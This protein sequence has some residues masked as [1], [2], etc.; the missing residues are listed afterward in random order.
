M[1]SLFL[2]LNTNKSV[3]DIITSIS[4]GI[5]TSND[6]K[7]IKRLL[8]NL[9]KDFSKGIMKAKIESETNSFTINEIIIVSSGC[10][11]STDKIVK[12]FVL[13]FPNKVILI[14]EKTRLGK[15]NALNKIFT[16]FSGDYLVLIPA[17]AL[18]SLKNIDLLIKRMIKDSNA[19]IAF[20]R[21]VIN[22]KNHHCSTICK[23]NSVL[24]NFHSRTLILKE[25]THASGELMVIRKNLVKSLP[26]T[27]INDDAYISQLVNDSKKKI[28]FEPCSIV[29]ITGPTIFKDYL[30]QR[31]RI[32]LGHKQLK[33]LGFPETT[34]F[35]RLIKKNKIFYLKLFLTEV[36]SL[37][38]LMYLNLALIVEFYLKLR[39]KMS[40]SKDFSHKNIWKRIEVD[41]SSSDIVNS[42]D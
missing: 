6:E 34:P 1:I 15:A 17:D 11:D 7:T 35:N 4:I 13:S 24:W 18:T 3:N 2:L 33:S 41:F 14:A 30:N 27:I 25:N 31:K 28:I 9:T 10:T 39:V 42:A 16:K 38:K 23:M 8:V 29:L 22:H 36:N 40:L 12:K 26:E 20:G 32:Y 21:P 5:C 19:G 37:K